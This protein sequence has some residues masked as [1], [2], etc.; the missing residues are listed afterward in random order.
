[1]SILELL[2]LSGPRKTDTPSIDN[3]VLD[4]IA[5]ELSALTRDEALRV[6]AFAYVLSRVAYSDMKLGQEEHS[7]MRKLLQSQAALSPSV[8]DTVT[9]MATQKAKLFGSTYNYLVTRE[10]NKIASPEEKKELLRAV[11]AVA[12][13]DGVIT[14]AESREL[15]QVASELRL[16]RSDYTDLRVTFREKLEENQ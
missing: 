6:A 3:E 7:R 10:F 8:A 16:D 2:G 15:R 11:F 1:M 14:S 13:A 12:A 5:Q 4:E 9:K